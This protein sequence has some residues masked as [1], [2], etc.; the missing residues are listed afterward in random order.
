MHKRRLGR[1][2]L[3]VSVIGFG[4][5]SIRALPRV[6]TKKIL[7]YAL[8]KGI[9]FFDTSPSYGNSE[10]KIGDLS[11]RREEYYIATKID[12]PFTRRDAK[13]SI[14]RSLRRLKTDRI[15]LIQLH[16][17]DDYE[18]LKTAMGHDGAM[19]ALKE[20][21]SEGLI[22]YIGITSHNIDLLESTIIEQEF[23]TVLV[24]FNT[25]YKDAANQL[26]DEAK[27]L[28]IGVIIMKPFAGGALTKIT[29]ETESI[30]KGKN[31]VE[32]A[33]NLLRF[34]LNHDISTI[35]PGTSSVKEIDVN[36]EAADKFTDLTIREKE[37]LADF[38]KEISKFC[39]R[40]EMSQCSKCL[41]CPE[42]IKI[43]RI[44]F[45]Y[46]LPLLRNDPLKVYLTQFKESYRNLPTKCNEC[47]KCE[48]RCPYE[49][50]IIDL[51]KRA[52][53]LYKTA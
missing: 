44:L 24:P 38:S 15:D 1:T 43:D 34:I 11:K 53:L 52:E 13:A 21:K 26:F 40:S 51:L 25:L 48:E 8:D 28:D 45:R 41:P 37:E 32:L 42:G 3:S 27:R 23:D 36:V 12:S 5:A 49:I 50:P 14:M 16:K 33:T 19:V 29:P 7:S 39:C 46:Q 20:A 47:G 17:I 31:T 9:N 10:E 4:G 18:E 2:D 30:F 35:I 22:D 6:K